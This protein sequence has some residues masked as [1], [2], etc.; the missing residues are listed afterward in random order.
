M[1]WSEGYVSEINYTNGFYGELSPLKLSLATALKSIHPPNTNKPFTYCELACGRGY[2]TNLLASAYPEAQFYANDFNPNHI[3]EAKTLAESANT[4]NVHFFDDSFAEFMHQD[5]PNF[6]FIVL[7][8]IYSWITADNRGFIVDFIRQKLKVGGIVYISYNTLPGWSTAMAMQGLMLKHRQHSSAPILESVEEALNFTE[9]LMNANAGYFLQNP[10]LKTRFE[11]LKSQN[12]HY[13]AHEYFN[14][15]WNSFYFDQVAQELQEAKLSYVASAQV[16]DN[17]D[18]LNF[19][20]DARKIL[21]QIKDATYKEVVRDF[22]LNTQ[23]RRDIFAKGKLDMMAAEQVNIMNGFRYALMVAIDSI[24]LKHTFSVGEVSLQEEIYIPIINALSKSPLTMAQLQNDGAVK[25]IAVNNIY[26]ALI[27][28]TGLGY[29]HPAVD[30]DT[31]Q[32]RKLSTDAFNRAI[33]ERA[34]ITDEMAYLASPLIGT[35]VAVNSLEQL[36]MYAKG[37]DKNPVKFLWDIFS[38]QGKRLVKDNQ[39]LQ[40]PQENIAYIEGVAK[41]FYGSRLDTLKKLGID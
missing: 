1:V 4:N 3:L 34:F 39:V 2:T 17:I 29:I 25:K 35:G 18:V 13:L 26:Q 37:K 32:R 30:D 19:S 8:G 23:F 20:A 33:Q 21:S 28:L 6:D 38:K 24:K 16:L 9:S 31:C 40:T 12:R 41:D 5:L 15:Q 27:V 14:E 7:H 22:C 11:N 36:L 10:S